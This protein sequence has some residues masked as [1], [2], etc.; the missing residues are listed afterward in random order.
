[1]RSEL[2]RALTIFE[3]TNTLDQLVHSQIESKQATITFRHVCL[4]SE[5]CVLLNLSGVFNFVERLITKLSKFFGRRIG[6]EHGLFREIES[7]C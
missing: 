4:D 2:K 5:N 6:R 3:Y 7:G 1:M